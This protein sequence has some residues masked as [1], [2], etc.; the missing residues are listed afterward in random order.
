MVK[1]YDRYEQEKSFG[2]ISSQS[3]IVWL[4]PS[5]GQSSK[6]IGRAISSGLEE[7]LVWDIKTGEI[8]NR[9]R[10]GLTPGASNASTSEAPSPITFLEYFE[11][12]NI[13]AAGY[14]DGSI[15][16]WDLT[17]TSV[18]ISFQGHKSAISILKFDRSGTR[19]VSGSSDSSIILWDL[20]GEE[21]LF[22]L[23]GHELELD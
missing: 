21:G 20:V 13:V 4:P 9:L 14:A 17:S 5:G 1:S 22:K 6:S 12:T 2:V 23:K 15:K 19:L 7:I 3:N 11:A 10:D 8:V 16:I 18:L